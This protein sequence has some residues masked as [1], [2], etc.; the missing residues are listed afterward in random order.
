MN[1]LVAWSTD[2]TVKEIAA[3]GVRRISV[4]GALARAA[5]GAFQRAARRIAEG[6]RFDGFAD[7]ASG[8]ELN[9]FFRADL[10]KPG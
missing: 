2:L 5:W 9:A 8:Q 10:V 6:G 3:L 7:A 1:L 4:G